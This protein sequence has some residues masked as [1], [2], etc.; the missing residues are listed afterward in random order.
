MLAG[1]AGVALPIIAHLLSRKKYDLVEW[2]AMQFLELDPSA[3][4]K[5]RLEEVLLLV[6]RIGLVAVFAVALARPWLGGQWL[7]RFVSTQSRDVVLIID[8][9]YSMG[10]EGKPVTPHVQAL[11]LARQFLK[12]LMPGDSIQIIDAREQPQVVLP[13]ATR[14]TY[15]VREALNDL[16]APS[17]SADL[18][19]AIN[20]AVQLLAA[21]TNLQRE[22]VVFTDLQA[23][24]WKVEDDIRWARFDDVRSQAPIAPRVWVIDAASGD[25]ASAA[26]FTVERIHLSRELAVVDIPIKISTTVKYSGGDSSIARKVYLEIDQRRL[27]DHSIQIKL[28]PKGESTVE[29]EYVFDSPGSHLISVVLDADALPGDNRADAVVTVTESLPALLVDGDKKLDPTKCETYFANAALSSMGDQRPWIKAKV[30]TPEELTADQLKDK[31]IAVIANVAKLNDAALD[32]LR[33]FAASGH[34]VLFTLGDKVDKDHYREMFAADR[35]IL[36]PCQ[37]NAVATEDGNEKR[38]VRVNSAS[39]E[40]PWLRP[41]RADQGGTLSDAR[42]SRWWKVTVTEG[43]RQ[44]LDLRPLTEFD[45]SPDQTGALTESPHTAQTVGTAIIEAR[46]TT[47]DPFLVSRRLG[48]GTTAVFSSTLDAD[49]NTLPAKQDY[50]P[51]LHELLFALASPTATRNL[52]VGTPLILPIAAD[53]KVEDYQFLNPVNKPFPAERIDDPFQPVAR[54]RKTALAGVYRF[55]PKK[56]KPNEP[57]RPEYFAVNFDRRESDLTP[58]TNEQRQTLSANDRMKFVT[59][60]PDLRQNMFADSSRVELWW[61]LLY[62][63]L[64]GLAAEAWMTRRMV[65]GG[66]STQTA[67]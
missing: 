59:D 43:D 29:F 6:L 38:G 46:L 9:S 45:Q 66:Y 8:G 13:E 53:L 48:R 40:L 39:L 37:L 14:D 23:M 2:G 19:A 1:L 62:L 58:L 36:F 67:P 57:N 15:R 41:F 32:S 30:I 42:F 3:K 18:P 7:G 49:W 16:P 35:A 44:L 52:D 5:I 22:I 21:G 56:P 51:F 33:Q 17:G 27:D 12:D 25:L 50:V 10:W 11:Q 24:A 47:G 61:L 31:A 20:R 26:N 34:A 54:L 63:F 64:I 60:L 65:R 4:R 28:Q 55:G